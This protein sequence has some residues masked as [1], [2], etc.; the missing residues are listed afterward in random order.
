MLD[1]SKRIS[2][3]RITHLGDREVFVFA[4]NLQGIHGAGAAK[5]AL[6]WGAKMGQG[7]GL[8]DRTYA[9]PTRTKTESKIITLP[10]S[11]IEDYVNEFIDDARLMKY[12]TFK[13]TEIGCGLAGYVPLQIAP[14]FRTAMALNNVCLP[15]TFWGVLAKQYA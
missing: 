8:A 9:I 7:I 1:Y 13:V 2:P 11:R 5:E 10:L 3:K 4:S 14:F 15:A 6:R 12:L